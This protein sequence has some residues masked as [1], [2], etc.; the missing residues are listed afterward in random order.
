VKPFGPA[1]VEIRPRDLGAN[2]VN[3]LDPLCQ[4]TKEL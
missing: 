3:Q 4:R 1:Q 2:D